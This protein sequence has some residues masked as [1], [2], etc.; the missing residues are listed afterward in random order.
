REKR[1][2]NRASMAE[3]S[4]AGQ[5]LMNRQIVD[6]AEVEAYRRAVAQTVANARYYYVAF[7][8]ASSVSLLRCFSGFVVLCLPS[9]RAE[10][11]RKSSSWQRFFQF[12]CAECKGECRSRA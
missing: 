9:D 11:I 2:T 1:N 5:L 4:V 7:T 3:Q 8:H 12:Q 10:W 6:F